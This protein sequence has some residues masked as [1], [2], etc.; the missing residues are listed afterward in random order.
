MSIGLA[1]SCDCRLVGN[2]WIVTGDPFV[3]TK[4][5]T[6][7]HLATRRKDDGAVCIPAT[8]EQ[9]RDLVWF[10]QRYPLRVNP[11]KK[12]RQ[13]AGQYVL[14][15]Q[16]AASILS[17]EYK[18]REVNFARGQAPRF[19]QKQAADLWIAM[20]G[21]LLADDVGTGKTITGIAAIVDE[22][23]R[24]ALIVV[25]VHLQTQWQ[26]QLK[27]FTPQIKSHII[28]TGQPYNL[29]LIYTCM[30][31][32]TDID[33][34]YDLK[35][36]RRSCPTCNHRLLNN[37]S[38][39]CRMADVY[40]MSYSKLQTWADKLTR[41]PIQSV[42]YDEAHHLRGGKKTLRWT[43][44]H[45]ISKQIPYRLGA[46]A[47]PFTN[48]GGEAYN[49]LEC[50]TPGRFGTEEQFQDTWCN[51]TATTK[52]PPLR[53]P[54]AFGRYCEQQGIMLRR[55]AKDLGLPVHDCEIIYQTVD[56]DLDKIT[57]A[58]SRAAELARRIVNQVGN[59]GVAQMEF[60]QTLRQ[61]TGLAKV[62]SVAAIV[63]MLVEQDEPVVLFAYH[64]AVHDLLIEELK[65]FSPVK[66][67]GE[68][69]AK[70]KQ[71]ALDKFLERKS[72]VFCISLRA[73]E[74][75]DGLQHVSSTAVVAELDWTWAV[76]K[77]N[78]GRIARDGQTRP[79][80]AY[81]PV[82]DFGSDPVVSQVLG[83]KRDQLN[84]FIGE[85]Q[86]GPVKAV[87]H[88]AAIRRLAAEYLRRNAS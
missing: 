66:Y 32:G 1:P 81:F 36:G 14:Q 15:Q 50:V 30:N 34:S 64:H 83:L 17:G 7:F 20:S 42:F 58:S 63:R 78:V 73:G 43:A 70:E 27:R 67:S 62:P 31:C 3:L 59:T 74:G 82:T 44:A 21:L 23:L 18:G 84:G 40:L 16:T 54:H 57:D 13:L 26:V 85:K 6:V 35:F 4:L 53:D 41:T 88:A 8:P 28:K 45:R 52:S 71:E 72:M 24:P 33:L 87:D 38:L 68:Q 65:D 37:G 5:S 60:D 22:R 10:M 46:T 75:L 51:Y 39:P 86:N 47:T 25:P 48:L 9:S 56:A 80:K 77:Q 2:E 49:V 76:V 12:L 79:C 29:D 69:N 55:T 19:Y 61:A 11:E